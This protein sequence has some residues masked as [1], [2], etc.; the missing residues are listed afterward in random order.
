MEVWVEGVTDAFTEGSPGGRGAVEIPRG[1]AVI[2]LVRKVLAQAKGMTPALL[3]EVL[4][5][6]EIAAHRLQHR[7]RDITR[8][9]DGPRKRKLSKDGWKVLAAIDR[10]RFHEPDTLI[11]AV[12]D[13]DGKDLPTRD[14]DEILD[15]LR[16]RG[17]TGVA[18]GV[19]IEEIEAWLLADP[20]AF[21]RYLGKGP[22]KGLSGSPENESD[23]KARLNKILEEYPDREHLNL[24]YRGL[25]DA[26]DL[27]VLARACPQGFG[28]FRAAL[29]ELVGPRLQSG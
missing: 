8:L 27:E 9:G 1:G 12:W 4:P 26:V 3:D 7:V 25:A 2:P 28:A 16:E 24:I 18:V 6:G 23:P 14:R 29:L 15:A 10:A 11:V 22:A 20:G 13:R 19:C 17:A 21:R 5:E